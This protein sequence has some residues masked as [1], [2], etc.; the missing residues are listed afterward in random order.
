MA[1]KRKNGSKYIFP[2]RDLRGRG[3]TPPRFILLPSCAV[4]NDPQ[5][6]WI[7]ARYWVKEFIDYKTSLTTYQDPLRGFGGN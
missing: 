3:S 4:S 1:Q 2:L 7:T 6:V 5:F